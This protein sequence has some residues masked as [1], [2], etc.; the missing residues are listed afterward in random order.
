MDFTKYNTLAEYHEWLSLGSCDS[1][2][3]TYT[4][5]LDSLLSDQYLIDCKKIDIEK[6]VEKLEAIKYK[7]KYSKSKNAFLKF[8][9]F[10]DIE[11]SQHTLEKLNS[12]HSEKTKKYRKL[13]SVRL[14]D[15]DNKIKGIRDKKL[16]ESFQT[17]L[18]TGLRRSEIEQLDKDS[19]TIS[20]TQIIFAF[21]GKGNRKEKAIIEKSENPKLYKDLV[22]RIDETPQDK[23]LFYSADYLEK[24]A[25]TKGFA[26]HDLRR[27]Y[28]K[29]EY[30]KT[31]DLEKVMKSLRH[32]NEKTTQIYLNSKVNID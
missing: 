4:K 30:K 14:S 20:N 3:D 6:V 24:K 19:C 5:E 18:A 23:K 15:I 17:L 1:T 28:A 8:A 16:K 13:K 25:K 7:N 10:L 29:L 31:G 22:Y 2:A 32:K 11:I 21:L 27:A 26:C 12:L 9:D